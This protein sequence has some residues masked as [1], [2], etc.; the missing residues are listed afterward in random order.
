MKLVHK[1]PCWQCPWLR[2]SLRGYLGAS[3]PEEFVKSCLAEVHM[4]CHNAIDYED[5]NWRDT[6][7]PDAPFCAGALIFMR[8]TAK[9]PRD[10]E[11]AK[12]RSQVSADTEN[13]FATMNEFL[14]HHGRKS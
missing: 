2:E 9:L 6:Q 8:N 12:A 7:L 14:A 1:K 4:P 10:P 13:V 11:L 5:P 3:T